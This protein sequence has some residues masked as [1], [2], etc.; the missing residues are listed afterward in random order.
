MR[1]LISCTAAGF[2]FAASAAALCACGKA[3]ARNRY[4]IEAEYFPEERLLSAEMTVTVTNSTENPLGELKFELWANAY[5]EGAL[6][7]PVSDLYEP[8]AY[9][10]GASYGGIAIKSVSD[11]TFAVGGEDENILTVALPAEL[12]P[13]ESATLS[14]QF[15]VTL[16]KVNHRLGAGEN[17][18]NLCD[19]YPVLCAFGEGGFLE[20]PYACYGDPFVSGCADF[21]VTLTVPESYVAAYGGT[22]ECVAQN[23]KK[24]YHVIAENARD[25][26]FVLGDFQSVKTEAEGVEIEYYYLRDKNPSTA[27]NAAAESLS[28]FSRTFGEYAYP[29]YVVAE[30]D[31]PYG[32]MENAAFSM[33][34]SSLREEE[35]PVVVAHETAHQWWYAMVGSNQFENAWQDEGLAEYSTALFFEEHPA[36][37]I[38]YGDMIASSESSYRSF[39]S[40][41]SQIHK[42]ANTAMDRPLTDFSGEYEYRN[43]AY[44]KGV[45]LFDRVRGAIGERRFF[46]ALQT[47]ARKYGGKIASPDDLISCFGAEG[48]FLSFTRGLCVI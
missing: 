18:V 23:G 31:F 15:D 47:Y 20:Y 39:F 33:I 9:Y 27:L 5:R 14:M 29:R 28:Y 16:A 45:I 46:S 30:T 38:G 1:R 11:G 13:D 34:S 22:G 10:D 7:A 32:G 12:Y 42:E 35:I 36:Y 24:T 43:I 8:S 21:D 6:Y 26:A 44:D 40:V 25:A 37:G 2:I 41:Y 4:K 19:F 48:L 17:C 3:E